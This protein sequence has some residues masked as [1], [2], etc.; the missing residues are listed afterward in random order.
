MSNNDPERPLRG[1]ELP[2]DL[3]RLPPSAE[4]VFRVLCSMEPATVQEV[5]D[6]TC[7]SYSTVGEACRRL[8][9]EGLVYRVPHPNHPNEWLWHTEY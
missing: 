1:D 2:A 4:L 7:S 8:R 6:A 9:S 3:H 5:A